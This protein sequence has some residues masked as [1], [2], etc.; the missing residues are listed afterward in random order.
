M[1]LGNMRELGVCGNEMQDQE[2]RCGERE[3]AAAS[4]AHNGG[5][6]RRF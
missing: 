3:I 2:G 6:R 1:T 5:L 4:P